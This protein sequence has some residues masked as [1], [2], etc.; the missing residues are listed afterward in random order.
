[1]M[2]DQY[3]SLEKNR[4][5]LKKHIPFVFFITAILLIPS[6]V[7][8]A[9]SLQAT[10][11]P[12]T[13]AYVRD[14][15][16]LV[17]VQV[18]PKVSP[19]HPALPATTDID[20]ITLISQLNETMIL[21]YLED[22]TAFGPRETGSESCIQ[23]AHYLYNTFNDMGLSVKYRNYTD[24]SASG[25]NI[26]ATLY[27]NTNDTNVF[28]VCAH[29]DSVA[30]GPGADDDG[31][32]VAAVLAA[33]KLLSQQTVNHTIR[34]VAFS[35]EEQ[36]LIGSR[37]Y[38]EEEYAN[39]TSIVAVL[40]AD[41]IGYTTNADDGHLGKIYENDASEW[42]V[43]YTQYI[44]ELYDP[45]IGIQLI[46]QGETWGSDHYYFW[47]YGYDAVFYHEFHFNDYYHSANDTIAHMNLTY[48]A[49]FSRLILA[50]LT[51]MVQQP[52][53]FLEIRNITGGLGV[54]CQII[55]LGDVNAEILN[56]SIQ[57]HGGVLKHINIDTSGTTPTLEPSQVFSMQTK[58]FGLGKV[59]IIITAVASNA[60]Q[61]SKQAS[62]FAFGPLV[63]KL[64]VTP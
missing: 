22:L 26:E 53:A 1:M 43:T 16:D 30:A 55:N 21:G 18:E 50:T 28:I 38:V 13:P 52:R 6:Y 32:G 54:S 60:N 31:S 8:G 20:I 36:G 61:V 24:A 34:F 57:I 15:D 27:G 39:N 10:S 29:Y 19:V 41:M 25:S 3:M 63:L 11:P 37:H 35:G 23:A 12:P 42:I 9:P 47:E 49:R 62:A 2:G 48:S 7:L 4:Q 14:F 33:A 45:Y 59:T 17:K 44:S 5:N 56:A 51:S 64:T 58:L 40:N 46:P